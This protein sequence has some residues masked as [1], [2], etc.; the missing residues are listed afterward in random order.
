MGRIGSDQKWAVF[1]CSYFYLTP[2]LQ[3]MVT[4]ATSFQIQLCVLVNKLCRQGYK[5]QESMRLLSNKIKKDIILYLIWGIHWIWLNKKQFG[6]HQD[7][8]QLKHCGK[9]EI[10]YTLWH[11]AFH[12]LTITILKQSSGV[13]KRWKS[14]NNIMH[15]E[16]KSP[17]SFCFLYILTRDECLLQGKYL[18]VIWPG[19]LK[20]T[21]LIVFNF[22]FMFTKSF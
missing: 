13:I 22:C 5:I 10:K 7:R 15:A 17:K 12:I 11:Y 16:P 6:E 1:Y 14:I 2:N 4:C 19:P 21:F 9:M 8:F 3:S 20:C 18:H